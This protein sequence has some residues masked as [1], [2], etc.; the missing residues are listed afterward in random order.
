MKV[1]RLHMKAFRG[2]D[3]LELEFD[4]NK[5]TVLVGVNGS[6]KSSILD[7]L[8]SLLSCLVAFIKFPPE[9]ESDRK[10]LKFMSVRQDPEG[11]RLSFIKERGFHDLD[12]KN[13]CDFTED[14]VWVDFPNTKTLNCSVRREKNGYLELNSENMELFLK[15]KNEE[16]I[17]FLPVVYYP[18]NRAVLEIPLG[19]PKNFSFKEDAIFEFLE[20]AV[21]FET[22]FEWFRLLEDIEN[23]QRRDD[24]DYRDRGLEAVRQ[25]IY[26][27]IP[28][29]SDL[30]V[31]RSPLR[32]TVNKNDRELIVNQ[33]SDG[34]RNLLALVGDLARR[35][36]I[37]YPNLDKPTEGETVVLIDEIEQHLHPGW[38]REVIPKLTHTF[39]NCQF[40]VTT[41][42]PQ[43]ISSVREVHLLQETDRGILIDKVPSY[44][45]DSNR[46]LKTLM[47]THERPQE[48]EN[49]FDKLFDLIDEEKLEE[50]KQIRRELADELPDRDPEFV[51]AD[52]LIDHLEMM[53]DEAHSEV[54]GT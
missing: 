43:V 20:E 25:A 35:L 8:V 24:P 14:R 49:A 13:N 38:Q 42:S 17:D 11:Q 50:A 54:A 1:K 15:A 22:F 23:E 53:N 44:G 37:V 46:I 2:F 12:I 16:D 3:D 34:E 10:S 19:I 7:C 27:L 52:W 5:P 29:F 26:S 51:K 28:G 30:R 40:I 32:M 33:L 47:D 4:E 18:S 39:P 36:A 45:K 31:R 6:G 48:I 9:V 41:H 21:G